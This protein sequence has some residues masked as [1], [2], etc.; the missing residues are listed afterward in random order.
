VRLRAVD[1]GTSVRIEVEDD[2]VGLPFEKIREHAIARGLCSE[3]EA[4]RL[5]EADLQELIFQP[6]FSTASVVNDVAG[7][8]VGL[9]VVRE[10]M[11]L[12]RGTV[13][14]RTSHGDGTS[15]TIRVPLPLAVIR[16]LMVRV[17]GEQIA[18]PLNAVEAIAK[19]A[20]DDVRSVGSDRMAEVGGVLRPLRQLADILGLPRVDHG[21]SRTPVISLR[22][23][24]EIAVLVV[25][26]VLEE[27]D[28]VVK[29]LGTPLRRVPGV[30]GATMLGD[31]RIVMIL[32][33]ADVSSR[34]SESE[35]VSPTRR[36]VAASSSE[37]RI[38]I[39][40]DSPSV[41]RVLAT[42]VKKAGWIPTLARDGVE[43]LELLR[44]GSSPQLVLTDIEMPRMDGFELTASLR[45]D[46][47]AHS[48]P[49][50]ILSSRAAEKHQRRAT[51]AGANA[52]LCKPFEEEQLVRVL[53]RLAPGEGATLAS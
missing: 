18:I 51:E 5:G 17:S 45:Q 24:G 50:V 1:E 20:P 53:N 44:A 48:I 52:Y 11:R 40:D 9:D 27:R 19:L 25:D 46:P 2:G 47:I 33:P 22:A 31:G 12:A 6:G 7:R 16:G 35:T 29:G 26:D 43:A 28:I 30:L 14:L 32:D 36:R 39:V 3:D 38:L 37:R 34:K 21:A 8:G 10:A 4:S 23:G 13:S 49:I 42:F 41:R 15:F